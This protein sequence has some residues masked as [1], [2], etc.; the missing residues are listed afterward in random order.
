MS[1]I[2]NE[3]EV[4]VPSNKV[5]ETENK[6]SD[7]FNPPAPTSHDLYLVKR[8]LIERRIRLQAR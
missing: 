6:I 4:I 5:E 7:N 3:V 8:K 1:V 2:V